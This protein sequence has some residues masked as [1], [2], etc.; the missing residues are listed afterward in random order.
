MSNFWDFSVWGSVNLVSVLLISLI[1]ANML[2]RTVKFLKYSLIPTSVL[3]GV[4]FI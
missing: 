3:D 4:F 2:K 1:L